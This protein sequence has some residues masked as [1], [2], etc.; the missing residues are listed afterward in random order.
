MK[1]MSTDSSPRGLSVA[2]MGGASGSGHR[3]LFQQTLCLFAR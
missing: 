1:M 2:K 3:C